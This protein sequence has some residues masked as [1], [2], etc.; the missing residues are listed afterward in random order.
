MT[1]SSN[2]PH[3]SA[4]MLSRFRDGFPAL[5]ALTYLSICD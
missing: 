4:Q 5:Q 1:I 3:A 2:D